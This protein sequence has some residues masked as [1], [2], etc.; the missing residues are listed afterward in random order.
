MDIEE[1]RPLTDIT[2]IQ[3]PALCAFVLWK[4]A[5]AHQ[6]RNNEEAILPLFFLVLPMVLHRPTLD[7]VLSTNKA[8]GL[9]LFAGKL[10]ENREDL[11]ALHD[12]ANR[13]KSLT[14]E[15]LVLG[16]NRRLLTI[17]TQDASVRA[18]ELGDG[19]K[20]PSLPERL[21][22]ITPAC[23]RVGYWFAGLPVQQIA[24]SLQVEF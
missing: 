21:R 6:V 17:K 8:S 11:I 3:N 18:N 22:W 16:E 2:L 10:G 4:F 15:A 1:K 19:Y 23:D 20:I 12:R 5:K 13:L 24:R 14:F 7:L 9:G